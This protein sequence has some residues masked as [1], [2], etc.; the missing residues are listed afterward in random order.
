MKPLHPNPLATRISPT[1]VGGA[2][3]RGNWLG[4]ASRWS[5]SSSRPLIAK[6]V[7]KRRAEHIAEVVSQPWQT[8]E[9]SAPDTT[10]VQKTYQRIKEV[11]LDS[12][13]QDRCLTGELTAEGWA[14]RLDISQAAVASG[15]AKSI[16]QVRIHEPE[17]GRV[18]R[19][20]ANA[21]RNLLT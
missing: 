16:P 15:D 12:Q 2:G 14:T 18:S 8:C 3:A 9:N 19:A 21:A 17:R 4:E 13:V 20:G 7:L 10:R 5:R 1:E 11:A 6:P